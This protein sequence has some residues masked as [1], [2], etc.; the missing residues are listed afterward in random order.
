MSDGEN[1]D[2]DKNGEGAESAAPSTPG[3]T[4]QIIQQ[5]ALDQQSSS[6]NHGEQPDVSGSAITPNQTGTTGVPSTD[7]VAGT[8][9]LPSGSAEG[10]TSI[11]SDSLVFEINAEANTATLVGSA[12]T[13][14]KSDLS[15]PA[16]VTSG[17]TTY[18]VT[19]IAKN[20]FA[21]CREL[22]SLSLPATL[23]EVDP[24][25]LAG[26]PSLKF[27]S[28]SFK[29][30]TFA[31]SD[32]MLFT[33]DYSTL[34]LIPEGKEGA[35]TIPGE[36]SSVPAQAFSR[37]LG[38]ASLRTGDG[39]A[40]LKAYN[41]MLFS[42]DL[43]TLLVC[44]AGAGSA[45]VLPAE[46]EA[47]GEYALAG[48]KNLAS[49]TALGN[50]QTIES[51]AFADEAKTSAVVA[52]PAGEN[53]DARKSVW[54]KVGFQ[55]FAEPAQ[56]GAT[57]HP[58]SNDAEAA[59][60]LTFTLQDDYTLSVAWE[61]IADP[62]ATL[63][64]PASAEING[65]TYQV[66]T[67]A[68][69][70]FTNR[71]SLTTVKLPSSV[72][73]IG[74]AA[75]A[76]CANLTT[77]ELPDTLQAIGGRAFEATALT[78]VWLP[79]NIATIGPRAF[80]ACESL[81]R[82]VALN[83]PEVADDA[84]AACANLSIYCPYN[85][86]GTYPWNLGLLANNNH[87]M[88]YGLSL[89][90]EPLI[91]EVGQQANLFE[92][93]L[94]E[95]PE[96]C[97][98]NYSYAAKPLSVENGI[99]TAKSKGTS[100]VTATLTL[101]GQELA[102]ATRSLE[103]ISTQNVIPGASFR[104]LHEG[105]D[106]DISLLATGWSDGSFKIGNLTYSVL[107]EDLKTVEIAKCDS[108]VTGSEVIPASVNGYSVTTIGIR[109]FS[110]CNKLTSIEIPSSVISIRTEAFGG[111]SSLVSVVIPDS[112][113]DFGVSAFRGCT[114][115]SSVTLGTGI[116]EI[117]AYAFEGDANLG[118][119]YARGNITYIDGSDAFYDVNKT[120]VKI[121]LLADA[122]KTVWTKKGFSVS[123]LITAYK[124][125]FDAQGIYTVPS[126]WQLVDGGVKIVEPAGK[127]SKTG[128]SLNW[129]QNA[130]G[131]GA[132]WNFS[133]DVMPSKDLNLCAKWSPNTYTLTFNQVNGSGGSTFATATF[134][135]ALPGIT[136]PFKSGYTFLGYYDQQSGGNQY[137][138]ASGAGT[139]TWD[140]ALNTTLYAQWKT[141]THTVTFDAN[142]G[143][144]GT[145][146]KV[147]HDA[148][149]IEPNPSPTKDGYT[150][151]G[152]YTDATGGNVWNFS[153]KITSDKTIYAHWTAKPYTI[154]YTLA[155]GSVSKPNPTTYTI[156]T[157]DFTLTNPTKS[158]YTFAGWTGTGLT[159]AQKS[160]TIAQG[161]TGD[162]SYTATWT[163]NKYQITFDKDGGTGGSG[164][165]EATFGAAMP[166]I[167][168]PSKDGYTF[169]GYYDGTTQYYN[170]DGSSAKNWDKDGV[171][172]LKAHWKANTY[173]VK[174]NQD[175]GEGGDAFVTVTFGAAMPQTKVPTKDG[176]TFA[177]YFDD[178]NKQYYDEKGISKADWDKDT[179]NVI[180]KA[181]WTL[182]LNF[183]FPTAALIQV[184][185]SGNVTGQDLEFE[186]T[187]A[188]AIKVTS[189]ISTQA[190]GAPSLFANDATLKGVRVLLTPLTG[191]G[192]Q[193]KVP[194]STSAQGEPITDGWTIAANSQL[195]VAF[196]LFLPE[197]AQFNY[198]A[199]DG[200]AHIANFSYEVKAAKAS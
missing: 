83:T 189:V 58:E 26:C 194:L 60:G 99:V 109:A 98:L 55:H 179:D 73:S 59:S 108:T 52:L 105:I 38:I 47:I 191:L 29:N 175:G 152:W 168:L 172:T 163:V 20:A 72:T 92:N 44:P 71:A 158:G 80:A 143:S 31:S 199:N 10:I 114:S 162:R 149:A 121:H 128:Y 62:D 25:A 22:T 126:S 35:A 188:E 30:D 118:A 90:E 200:Q 3:E 155:G 82:I 133:T 190:Q 97:T 27:I 2:A 135:A 7:Q 170:A 182:Q 122:D 153:T 107:S 131:T 56:P 197:G 161:S 33:N 77:I 68:P 124:L 91:L 103:V 112:V 12:T 119:I 51:T 151:A 9:P 137:Y 117:S 150:F 166:Q 177:G 70:A 176:Y 141:N 101:N 15:I 106:K 181:H 156:E 171:V 67:I 63:E 34:L 167:Q 11:V 23:R 64:I 165:V 57:T 136:I 41:G 140:K 111:C 180:L 6:N 89:P 160:V 113:T 13:A 39:G 24:D 43:K 19:A 94:Y 174:F 130:A 147:N 14:P 53:Y 116:S 42:K 93:A 139:R 49:I 138:N 69:N 5:V 144:G 110:Y 96:G 78:D 187:S 154:N 134:D 115:L 100:E 4:A 159:G 40:E 129:Y 184:D 28:V 104:T 193:V 46:T 79:A 18:E 81:T 192:A 157:A 45:A 8:V 186:S 125:S 195:S 66:S 198:L 196:S 120:Q 75:F 87:L 1:A 36:T 102:S 142:G 127:P 178:N 169:Q 123:N 48:C 54:E 95:V 21:N 132:A 37:C 32:G 164:N 85:V 74:E 86:E 17:A 173:T 88:P 76:G 61:G 183:T 16:S 185:A 145:A 50:V 65:V 146:Q 84:L 148:V